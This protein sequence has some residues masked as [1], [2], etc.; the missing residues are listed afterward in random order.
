VKDELKGL[1]WVVISPSMHLEW[2][3]LET[4]WLGQGTFPE[5]RRVDREEETFEEEEISVLLEIHQI[6]V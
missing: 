6:R 5:T 4:R 2:M 1:E 3:Y